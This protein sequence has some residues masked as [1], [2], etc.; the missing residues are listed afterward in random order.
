MDLKIPKELE[1]LLNDYKSKQVNE[2]ERKVV[3]D[4]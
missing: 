4:K 3:I 1:I 2:N